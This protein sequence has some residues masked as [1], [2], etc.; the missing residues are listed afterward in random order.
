M[1][2]S[3]NYTL[4]IDSAGRILIPTALRRKLGLK[5]NS[6]VTASVKDRELRLKSWLEKVRDVQE[7]ARKHDRRPEVN[8]VDLLI[9]E[10][11]REAEL[12]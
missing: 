8:A 7:F 10:R 3:Q 2:D 6:K 1:E 4:K 12:E 9:H 11:R 5:P